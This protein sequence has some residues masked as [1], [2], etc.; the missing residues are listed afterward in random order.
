ME[1]AKAQRQL[2][3]YGLAAALAILL[4]LQVAFGSWRL[5]ALGPG[6]RIA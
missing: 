1:R 3:I 6:A 4:L 5:A 2:L